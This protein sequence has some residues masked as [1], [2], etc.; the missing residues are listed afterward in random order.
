MRHGGRVEKWCEKKRDK[1]QTESIKERET[2]VRR[3]LG[4]ICKLVQLL[5]ENGR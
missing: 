1:I 2:R 4:V 3:K 5:E